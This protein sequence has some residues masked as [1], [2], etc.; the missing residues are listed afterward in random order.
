MGHFF[1]EGNLKLTLR[2][3]DKPSCGGRPWGVGGAGGDLTLV[4]YGKTGDFTEEDY[5]N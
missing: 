1:L 5:A 4:P 2:E 3:A